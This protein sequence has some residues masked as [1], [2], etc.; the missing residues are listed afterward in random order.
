VCVYTEIA[1]GPYPAYKHLEGLGFRLEGLGFRLE[2]LGFIY[3]I[4]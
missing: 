2:G 3:N 1:I 4:P